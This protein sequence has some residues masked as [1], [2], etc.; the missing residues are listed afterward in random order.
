MLM[1]RAQTNIHVEQILYDCEKLA[2]MPWP[3]GCHVRAFWLDEK[4]SCA[5]YFH[6]YTKSALCNKAQKY[7]LYLHI[8]TSVLYYTWHIY[9]IRDT[10][11]MNMTCLSMLS[12]AHV[13]SAFVLQCICIV[14]STQV[15]YIICMNITPHTCHTHVESSSRHT[16]VQKYSLHLLINISVTYQEHEY[17]VYSSIYQ[18]SN[19]STVLLLHWVNI[20]FFFS[21]TG[22]CSVVFRLW[23]LLY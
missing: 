23:K 8:D 7:S 14:L 4:W 10:R 15:W 21:F 18:Y 6:T 22:F 11:S 1:L 12:G 17:D 9:D 16:L 19:Q 2:D 3:W 20:F 13:E 5:V